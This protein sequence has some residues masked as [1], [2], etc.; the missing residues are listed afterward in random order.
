MSSRC[1]RHAVLATCLLAGAAHADILVGDYRAPTPGPVLRFGVEQTGNRAPLAS[2]TT[3]LGADVMQ[4]PMS[5]TYEPVENVVWV[6]DYYGQSIRVYP[7]GA[8][9]N[10][11]PLRTLTSTH[12]GQPRQTAIDRTHG[13]LLVIIQNCCVAAYPLGASGDMG[14]PIRNVWWG[15]N[16]GLSRLNNPVHLYY[17]EASDQ[18]VVSDVQYVGG[19]GSGMLLF[20]ARTASGN[21][22]P[23]RVIEGPSTLLGNFVAGLAYVPQ[24]GELIALTS[25][26][27]VYRLVT[28]AESAS[29]DV[30]PVRVIEGPDL[31]IEN[32]GA[33]TYDAGTDR[34]YVL[35][36][37][38]NSP[39]PAVLAFPRTATGNVAPVRRIAGL[40]TTLSAPVGIVAVPPGDW[41]FAD[42]FND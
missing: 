27:G 36:G 25:T 13:E 17:L 28:F 22:A 14:F 21:V 1:L 6:S 9:G 10:V 34:I 37:S 32:P 5:M 33:I 38:Y 30:A 40:R 16:G 3:N 42:T 4:T 35:S 11:A 7:V 41:I 31:G 24:H 29:G 19:V 18:V 15:G 23:A 8:S 20:F 26:N 39:N 2:L 12:L